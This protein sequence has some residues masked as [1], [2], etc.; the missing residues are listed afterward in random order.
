MKTQ[1]QSNEYRDKMRRT[2]ERRQRVRRVIR[3]AFG[4]DKW[5][6]AI[7]SSYVLWPK[8]ERRDR[9][10]RSID[11]RWAERRTQLRALRRRPYR[12]RII[13]KVIRSQTLTA[14]ER[15]MLNDLNNRT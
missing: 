3:A 1:T 14:E 6:A 5:I 12:Q 10:R 15:S 9:E 2:T 11:R 13:D 7:Q 4:S 8:Q